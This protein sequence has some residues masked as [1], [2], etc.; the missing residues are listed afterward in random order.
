MNIEKVNGLNNIIR[1]VETSGGKKDKAPVDALSRD[2][3]EI[4]GDARR[5]QEETGRVERARV[6]QQVRAA[7]DVREE[8]I[9][10]LRDKINDPAYL[11]DGRVL[12]ELSRRLAG[13]LQSAE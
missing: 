1:P 8:R 5:L 13:I 6:E 3:V 11:N 7:A 2:S 12:S 10:E 4:S 9:A